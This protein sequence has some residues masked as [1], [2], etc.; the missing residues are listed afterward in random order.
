MTTVDRTPPAAPFVE[1][2]ICATD[3]KLA[4]PE[5]V[6]TA[7][8]AADITLY[9]AQRKDTVTGDWITVHEGTKGPFCDAGQA[10][11]GSKATYRGRAR[12]AAGNWSAYS[13][14]TTFTLS[15]RS[16]R[17]P[18]PTPTST[19]SPASRI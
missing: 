3:E 16:R 10:A 12:D 4:G 14:A 7:A 19:T 11:D 5:L 8:N 9:Q 13:A 18:P 17:R 2:D 1:L 15:T 6:T